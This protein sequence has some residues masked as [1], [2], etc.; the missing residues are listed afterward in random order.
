MCWLGLLR[1]L[2]LALGIC[3][4]WPSVFA[5]PCPGTSVADFY[6]RYVDC[7]IPALRGIPAKMAAGDTNA[8]NRLFA[9]YVRTALDS[10]TV[11]AAWYDGLL[12]AKGR[13]ALKDAAEAVMDYRLS[14]CG[15]SYQFADHKIDWELNPT[16]NGYLE[17]PWQLGRQKFLT[18]L[19]EYYVR[20][21][22][23]ERAAATWRD[24]IDSWIDQAPPPPDGTPP[25]YP[26]SPTTW[27]T[28]DAALRVAGWCIQIHAFA[29]SPAL[30][31]EFI[32]RFFRS[33]R[34][35]GH[36]LEPALTAQNWRIMELNGL[37]HV[38]MLF[39]FLSESRAWREKA[40]VEFEQQL[41]LQVYPDGF[42]FELAPGYHG[43]IPHDYGRI[44][45]LFRIC[46]ESPPSFV[47]KG[48]ERAY[49]VYPRLSRPDRFTPPINDSGPVDIAGEMRDAARLY[50][51]REDFRWFATGGAEGRKPDYLSCAF[52]YAGAAVFRSSW[53]TNAVWGYMDCSPFG[54]AHQHEDK[55]NIL[56][57]AYGKNML[58]DPGNYAY[59]GSDM[60]KYVVSTR[61]HNTILVDGLEQY[62][63]RT[64][65]W[66]SEEI[67]KRADFVWRSSPTA[68]FA[69]AA[70]TVGYGRNEKS[71]PTLHSRT[72]IF[73][74]GAANLQPF[75]VV[76]DRLEAP[77]ARERTYD[78]LWHLEECGLKV[79]VAGFVADF[80]DGVG[81]F[82]AFSDKEATIVDMR[83]SHTPYQGWVPI[84]PPGPHEHRPIPTPV[85]KGKFFG[86]RRIVNV[87]YPYRNGANK[88]AGV[89][90]SPD[91]SETRFTIE[92]SDGAR[93]E[94]DESDFS[95]GDARCLAPRAQASEFAKSLPKILHRS[96]EHYKA[97]VA[98][99]TRLQKDSA[100]ADT[101]AY[102]W[103]RDTNELDM[104]PMKMWTGGHFAGALWLLHEATGD[105]A[106]ADAALKWTLPLAQ[107]AKV[108]KHHDVGFLINCSF[109]NARRLLGTDRFDSLIVEAATTL[110]SRFN[111]NLGLIRSGGKKDDEK[112]FI[113][114][115]DNLMNLELFEVASKISG[116][117]RLSD[118]AS[119][120]A[121]MTMKH[122]YRP[123]GGAYHVLNY[124]QRPEFIGRVQEIRRGQG[125]SCET[126][127]SRGQ[128]WSVYGYAMMFRETR[129]RRFLKMAQK[130]AD[131]CIEHENM[132]ED[133]VPYWD[134]GANCEERDSSAGAIL[135]SGLLELASFSSN[136]KAAV[137]RT[138]AVK[139]LAALA[140]PSFFSAHGENGDFLLMHGVGSKPGGHAVDAPLNYGDY[141]F[142]EALLRFRKDRAHGGYL[143]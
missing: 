80:G 52:P 92:L 18:T 117:R 64:W 10:R 32:V 137:Y 82:A 136:E 138:F 28:L 2:K 109:G 90:A 38:A 30:S 85:L 67:R 83:G 13:A 49:E 66:R 126:A 93:L 21:G 44:L 98:E 6:G 110:A 87:F 134:Y 43:V 78:S 37:L 41:D 25:G 3:L 16:Y 56:I 118:I 100:R 17:W 135:A 70:Y 91:V 23:D 36:R 97:L 71:D 11:N 51:R 79:N 63:R 65:K 94:L 19:A 115:P 9:D 129:D 95:D 116:D 22:H 122:H 53:E 74:K 107:N 141:Y 99:A 76:V 31:D 131:F 14:A 4:L 58:I 12:T 39:P 101:F 114:I 73:I 8:A 86:S 72:A 89:I 57:S 62:T 104:R 46:G 47:L 54:R 69:R 33:V 1:R 125:A 139:A 60:R 75:F 119:S 111:P 105:A 133:G 27:R 50:P 81:L 48:I 68:D 124:D 128:S 29:K 130:C 24:M 34:D 26:G 42:Q 120:H 20:L 55:L 113:V 143:P 7:S 88:I 96:A 140:S 40:L 59:D 35:H 103:K 127:W 84:S 61:A 112:D 108:D 5:V 77:D 106:F 132:P 45:E 142:L 121:A 15:V 123:D 102:S